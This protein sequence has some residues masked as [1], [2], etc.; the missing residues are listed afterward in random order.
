MKTKA[1]YYANT[2]SIL[3]RC[4]WVL[5]FVVSGSTVLFVQTTDYL[6]FK[7]Q[8][9]DAKS[10][11]PIA[12]VHLSVENTNISS[13]A[14]TNGEFT[15]KV[16]VAHKDAVLRF[17]KINY[18]PKSMSLALF[19]KDFTEVTLTPSTVN[20]EVLDEVE[21]Y[22]A[23]DPRTI[24]K[25]ALH[26]RAPSSEKLVGFYREKIDRGRRNVM[27]GEAV[28]QI[29]RSKSVQG[30]KGEM[31]IYKSRKIT[32]YKRLDTLAVKLRGGPY[33]ALHLDVASFPEYLFYP[34][35]VLDAYQFTFDKPT[36]IDNRYIYV[37]NFEQVN[38]SRP[39]YYG[40]MY[41]DAKSHSLVKI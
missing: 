12:E 24:V 7:G 21:V 13:L 15:L 30:K 27:L 37:I 14:N 41:I 19:D 34:A 40:T 3:E 6:E 39:W 2:K 10:G 29:D 28:V 1:N 38:K 22:R 16:P 5:L 31:A 33:T 8:V 36:T 26:K 17:F 4:M 20:T 23:S 25:K 32:D 18:E 35:E 9:S 11:Q